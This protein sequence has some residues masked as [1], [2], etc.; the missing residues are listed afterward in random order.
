MTSF[1][2]LL[3]ILMPLCLALLGAALM[4][5]TLLQQPD[6]GAIRWLML[7]VY[8]VP[9]FILMRI[10]VRAYRQPLVSEPASEETPVET[11]RFLTQVMLG[12]I[13]VALGG[14]ALIVLGGATLTHWLA[15]LCTLLAVARLGVALLGPIPLAGET[16]ALDRLLA[17][18]DRA[19]PRLALVVLSCIPLL[20]AAYYL[21]G[22]RYAKASDL[23]GVVVLLASVPTAQLIERGRRQRAQRR[24][25]PGETGA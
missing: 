6:L 16:P 18:R 7:G 11:R 14:V 22:Y 12:S 24:G 4:V 10:L 20:L 3:L 25:A 21:W 8:V 15:V 23:A 13:Y 17:A 9:A 1:A 19:A 5:E 2:L